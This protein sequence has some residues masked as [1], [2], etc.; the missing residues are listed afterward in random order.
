VTDLR[1]GA[2]LDDEAHSSGRGRQIVLVFLV[3]VIAA[4]AVV[5]FH[6]LIPGMDQIVAVT[7][8]ILIV[9]VAATVFI[10]FRQA[11]RR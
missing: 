8:V 5:Q 6:T 3:I 10:L 1:P 7:P 11:R 9:V 2:S 4:V